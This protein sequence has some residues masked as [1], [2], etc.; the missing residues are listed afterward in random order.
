MSTLATQDFRRSQLRSTLNDEGGMS[1]IYDH[2]ERSDL[3]IKKPRESDMRD[4]FIHEAQISQE[5]QGPFIQSSQGYCSDGT[6]LYQKC[7]KGDLK[8]VLNS[9]SIDVEQKV[10]WCKQILEGHKQIVD[11][12]YAHGDYKPPNFLIDDD[13]N[14]KINDFGG[15][16]KLV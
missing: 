15:S 10:L 11:K 9:C 1:K 7:P 16:C 4:E 5:L 2:P 6:C 14:I 12:N 8:K 3:R 13:F